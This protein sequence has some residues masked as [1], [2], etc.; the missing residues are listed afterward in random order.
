[1]K[2]RKDGSRAAR[3]LLGFHINSSN[4]GENSA[5]G[6]FLGPSIISGSYLGASVQN[7]SGCVH[8][9]FTALLPNFDLRRIDRTW[10]DM[11]KVKSLV[12][13]SQRI[14]DSPAFCYI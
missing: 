14:L 10:S 6:A 8:C 12:I 5:V 1:M 11:L 13:A 3:K 7:F 9:K 4:L 2:E